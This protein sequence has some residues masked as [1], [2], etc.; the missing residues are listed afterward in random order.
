MAQENPYAKYRNQSQP[1]PI[2]QIKPI[3]AAPRDPYEADREA[4]AQAG[5]QRAQT[6]EQRAQADQALQERKFQM[7]QAKF[8]AETTG[9]G[10][11]PTEAQ[12][13]ASTLVTRIAGGFQD[14]EN[15]LSK[16][17][18]AQAPGIVE[19]MRGGLS[20][21]GIMAPVTRKIAGEERRMV[22][23]AQL[24]VLDALLTLGTG[25]A[26]SPQQLEAQMGAYFPQYGD[27]QKEADAK[28][29]RMRRMI[30]AAKVNAGPL[31]PKLDELL[32]KFQLPSDAGQQAAG[33]SITV[34][35]E[36]SIQA[37][38]QLTYDDKGQLVGDGY[39]GEAFDAAGNS[40]GLIG[41]VSEEALQQPAP[42][43]Y[44]G[45]INAVTGGDQSTATTERL[46]DWVEMPGINDLLSSAAW[47]TGLG[48]VF[49]GSP[50]EI[51]QIVQS[52]F[53]GTQVW[54]DEK[55]NYIL[56]SAT[57][58]KDYAI[59]PG[60][61]VSDIPRA[62][63][64]IGL[65]MLGGGGAGAT[66]LRTGAREAG[67]QAGVEGV[68]SATG[69][70][71]NTSDIAAAGVLGAGGQKATDVFL[72][73]VVQ[74]VNAIRR[75]NIP[76]DG[77]VPPAGGMGGGPSGGT[78]FDLPGGIQLPG[79]R[80][81][82]APQGAM[83][84]AG[85]PDQAMGA[86]A[87]ETFTPTTTTFR[88]GG[89]EGT[90][91]DLIRATQAAELGIDLMPFQRSRKFQDMQRAH[92]LAKNG[93]IGLPIRRRLSEQQAA[94]AQKFDDYIDQTG[95]NIR[96]DIVGQGAKITDAMGKMLDRDK[97]RVRTLYSRASKSDEAK[98]VVPLDQKIR[99]MIDD[100]EV[101]ASVIDWLNSQPTG[102]QTSGVT[103][104]A[105]QLAVK[106]GIASLDKET[107]NLVAKQPTVKA[108]EM[109]RR[110]I[111]QT[112]DF[113]DAN[114]QRQK[115]VLKRMIDGHTE[116]YATGLYAEARAARREVGSK[117][118]DVSTIAQLLKT[119]RNTPERLIASE[120]VV[121]SLLKGGTSVANVK[122]L[123]NLITGEGGDPQ[124]WKEVQGATLEYLR[125][126]AFGVDPQVEGL[127][128]KGVQIDEFGNR[129]MAVKQFENAVNSLDEAGKL[130]VLLGFE[131]AN[132]VRNLA[133]AANAM[134]TAPPGS[135]N[136]SNTSSAWWNIA[137][138]ILNATLFQIPLPSGVVSNVVKPL[139]DFM[140]DRPL[141]KEVSR[142]V[143]GSE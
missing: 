25:A 109:W 87:D 30:E 140:K 85:A 17:P 23:D 83:P 4:R 129:T 43:F 137:D 134:F 125:K 99:T 16:S 67:I 56:R 44:E 80:V 141:K 108:L 93:E 47:K 8:Q 46:P 53:P 29:N 10:G 124:A 98:T 69:G 54:Q 75:G 13:K 52:N 36:Q 89:A 128:G 88:G 49:G 20:P 81:S 133:G 114:L 58:G 77:G 59:K 26:Y 107:G 112:S 33:P 84:P 3:I 6:A 27:T 131:K 38:G 143:G 127:T 106:L 74:G 35:P 66:A 61:Q 118:E 123:R 76:P 92:E 12:Q 132:A 113:N 105:K 45:A 73:K 55:G 96:G 115:T 111:N 19:T 5:E 42:S 79:G 41:S 37:F 64:T 103:D 121:E 18:E 39:T 2:A 22:Y 1:V 90:P 82:P 9:I 119:K 51:A 91:I 135:V 104:A 62:V 100:E 136:F 50:Q 122:A 72:P 28:N 71:F 60:F 120:K 63:S 34:T 15:V 70:T 110:E 130:D 68:Q 95:S 32:V 139:K 94:I 78:A 97:A 31:A 21:V 126:K 101:D 138:M 142:L 24:D 7:E 40:L 14:I 86:M 65:G 57:D 48:T 117:Y 116:P 102:L 11:K